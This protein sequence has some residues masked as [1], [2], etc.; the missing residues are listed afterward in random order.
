MFGRVSCTEVSDHLTERVTL[1]DTSSKQILKLKE[2]ARAMKYSGTG[3]NLQARLLDVAILFVFRKATY[4]TGKGSHKNISLMLECNCLLRHFPL[5]CKPAL[6]KDA[7]SKSSSFPK[8]LVA[9]QTTSHSIINA[10]AEVQPRSG[11]DL[12]YLQ[13]GSDRHRSLRSLWK[14]KLRLKSP[15]KIVSGKRTKLDYQAPICWMSAV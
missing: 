13:I 14:W 6:R 11:S 8:S 3:G 12:R 10:C 5:S 7:Q 4:P 15:G 9:T 1:S 2:F